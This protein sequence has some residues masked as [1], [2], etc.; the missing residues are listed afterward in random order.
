MRI[1]R[2]EHE[3]H[4]PGSPRPTKRISTEWICPECEHFEEADDSRG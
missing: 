2:T 1:K 3:V 4:V